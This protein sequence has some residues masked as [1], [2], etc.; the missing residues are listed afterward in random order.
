MQYS[1]EIEHSPVYELIMS[2]FAFVDKKNHGTLDLGTEWV[3]RVKKDFPPEFFGKWA[4]CKK[5]LS[6][7]PLVIVSRS[8]VQTPREFIPWLQELAWSELY[9]IFSGFSENIILTKPQEI[10]KWQDHI[11]DLLGTW[12][13]LYFS[14]VEDNVMQHLIKDASGVNRDLQPQEIVEQLSNGIRLDLMKELRLVR[15]IPHYHA[16]P[17]NMFDIGDTEL[18]LCYPCGIETPTGEPPNELVRLTKALADSSR[19]KIL[20]I[21]SQRPHTFTEVT[22]KMSIAKSTVHHHLT[23]LRTAG[24]VWVYLSP[25]RND[26]FSL[27]EKAINRASEELWSYLKEESH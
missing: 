6:G 24:L 2:F 27:R 4:E 10:G 15:L 20:R 26:L 5:L 14:K 18:I 25:N 12:Y 17:Y 3:K 1:V 9:E 19:L 21:L 11:C 13:R 7:F 8:P 16:R 22:E 23:S